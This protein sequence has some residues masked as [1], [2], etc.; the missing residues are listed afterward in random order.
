[1]SADRIPPRA[2]ETWVI[3]QDEHITFENQRVVEQLRA[4]E[5]PWA[6][7]HAAGALAAQVFRLSG[8]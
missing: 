8:R 5:R 4:R 6:Q 2:R 3:V 7:F 1:L